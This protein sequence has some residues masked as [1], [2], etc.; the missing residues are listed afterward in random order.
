MIAQQSFRIFVVDDMPANIGV[1]SDFLTA[2]GFEV[3][4]AQT[5]SS[6]L[7]K[8]ENAEPHL[9]LLDIFMPGIDGFETCRRLKANPKTKGIPIIFMTAFKD[10]VDKVKGLELGAVDYVTKPFQQEEILARIKTHLSISQLQQ[11]LTNHNAELQAKN[12]DL[13]TLTHTLVQQREELQ[14]AYAELARAARLKD[15]FLANMSHELRTP[16]NAVLGIAEVLQEGIYGALNPK[17]IKSI[18]TIEEGGQH[19]LSV[20]N[21][22]LNLAKIE[23]GKVKLEMTPVSAEEIANACLRLIETLAQKKSIKISITVNIDMAIIKADK[24][25]LKQILFNLLGNA[26]KF[27]PE[28]GEINL[29]ING[30]SKRGTVDFIVS[31]TGIGIEKSCM[32][33]LFK[34]FVQLDSGLNKAY[35]GTGLGLSLVYRLTELHGG[36]VSVESELGKGSRFTVSLPWQ[37]LKDKPAGEPTNAKK[38]ASTAVAQRRGEV[39]LLVDDNPAVIKLLSDYLEVKSYQVITAYNGLQA[40]EKSKEKHPNLIFMDIQ[41]PNMDGLEATRRIRADA[42]IATI[43]IV[44]LTALAMPGNRE[45]CLKA[46]MNDYLSKPVSFQELIAAIEGLL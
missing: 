38:T 10:T 44:A 8:I 6:A 41:M 14:V 24:R 9:I 32:D 21:D 11:Q 45:R 19:L 25:Q 16:L 36:C 27:T 2:Q 34:P 37:T 22:I 23:A 26:V 17:Q 33:M 28:R 29:E 39:I 13:N 18:H 40:I 12:A 31:D 15:E 5:G 42:D 46:G 4:I 35:N 20:I 30:D 1:L 7:Q 3:L 43:P